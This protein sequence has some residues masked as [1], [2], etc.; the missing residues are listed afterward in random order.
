MWTDFTKNIIP[1]EPILTPEDM[2]MYKR[3]LKDI[4]YKLY[5]QDTNVGKQKY[6][7]TKKRF[8]RTS[9]KNKT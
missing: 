5:N 4:N 1:K 9:K 8:N 6:N 3:Y 2:D 7:K